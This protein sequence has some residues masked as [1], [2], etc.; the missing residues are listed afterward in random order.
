MPLSPLEGSGPRC[1]AEIDLSALRHNVRTC[2]EISGPD[3]GV[4]AVVKADAYGHGLKPVVAALESEVDWFGVANLQEAETVR[5]ASPE[6]KPVL[7][8]SP[9]LPDEYRRIVSGRHSACVSTVEEIESYDEVAGALRGKAKLH[10]AVD[11]GMGRMGVSPGHFKEL[12]QKI[13][14]SENCVLEG[15]GSHFPSADEDV[16]FTVKQIES[17]ARLLKSVSLP[18]NTVVHLANSAGLIGFSEKM[19]FTTLSRP[20][21]A[22]YGVSPLPGRANELR[23]ALKWKARVTLVR[24]LPAGWGV[25]Y[26]RTFVTEKPMQVATL[27]AGYGDGYPRH[28]SGNGADVLINETRC[29]ILGRVTMDQIVVD[30]SHLQ[31]V[32]R[33]EE[34]ILIGSQGDEIISAAEIA[35]K[36]GTIPWEI[37]TGLTA[38]VERAYR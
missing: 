34:A 1:S 32:S 24:E 28:A 26:G 21:L 35:E 22:I 19:P 27:S 9:A 17:F 4:M 3:S 11:T 12:V 18:A 6:G 8:L 20:G 37:F 15:V 10:L 16:D 30:V 2:Q 38:R 7:I 31:N 36:A 14:A 29:P 23:P 25:S 33:G 5:L 13:E